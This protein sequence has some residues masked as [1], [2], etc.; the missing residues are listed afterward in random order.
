MDANTFNVRGY[1]LVYTQNKP[2]TD[3]VVFKVQAFKDTGKWNLDFYIVTD[4][5]LN[6]GDYSDEGNALFDAVRELLENRT[7]H[8]NNYLVVNSEDFFPYLIR[9]LC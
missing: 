2:A 4:V 3:K 9:P 8:K 7:F 5:K 1:T 6:I